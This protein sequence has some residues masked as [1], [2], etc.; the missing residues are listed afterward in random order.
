[1]TRYHFTSAMPCKYMKRFLT[2]VLILLALSGSLFAQADRKYIRQGNRKYSKDN[3]PESEILYRRA[4]DK[5][6]TSADA[7]FNT[8]DALYKQKKYSE[9]GEK[10]TE[11]ISLNEDKGKKSAAWYNLG[12]SLVLGNKLEESIEAYKN[13]LRL[14]P[15][16]MEAKHNLAHAQD[17]LRQ[18]KEQ[19]DKQNNQQNDQQDKQDNQQSDQQNNNDNKDQQQQQNDNQQ[20][21]DQEQKDGQ[22]KQQPGTQKISPEDAQRLLDAIANDEKNVQEKVQQEKAARERVK[23][24]KN[25]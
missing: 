19:Q 22:Q 17:L 16:S 15:G 20:D 9:A 2:T 25:W 12:N 21:K 4:T 10:F 11:N 5:N 7:V 14:D 23:T 3:Y 13:A 1:M 6:K 18:Q 24:E 8:G